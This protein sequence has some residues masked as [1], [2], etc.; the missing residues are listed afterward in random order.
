MFLKE[1]KY[2]SLPHYWAVTKLH[3]EADALDVTDVHPTPATMFL[4][5]AKYCSL[6]HY[7][8]VTKLHREADALDVTDVHPTPA[9]MFL[10][11]AKYCSLPHYRAA[12]KLLIWKLKLLMCIPPLPQCSL[13]LNTASLSLSPHYI[14]MLP[15]SINWVKPMPLMC[16]PPLPLCSVGKQNMHSL[17]HYSAA[18]KLLREANALDVHPTTVTKFLKE[19]KS[20]S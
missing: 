2:C 1:A 19:A 3:R 10:K 14:T 4:K 17:P 5:E 11:E 16:I 18:T 15:P 9:T 13:K 12:T 6:P 7:R 20:C 8:A